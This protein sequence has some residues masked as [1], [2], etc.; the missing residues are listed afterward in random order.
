MG[1]GPVLWETLVCGIIDLLLCV[2]VFQ[3]FSF[4]FSY[5][6]EEDFADMLQTTLGRR[7]SIIIYGSARGFGMA[8]YRFRD[9]SGSMPGEND[10]GEHEIHGGHDYAADH[11]RETDF[12]VF[13][14][15]K[16]IAVL[17]SNTGT[18]YVG[19]GTDQCTVTS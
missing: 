10:V 15:G 11:H 2:C 13:Y 14:E 16:P 7:P 6:L 8:G 12:E 19:G 17:L 3:F 1:S 4:P 9:P 18:H 5:W